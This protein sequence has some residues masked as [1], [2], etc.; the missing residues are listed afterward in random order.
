MEVSFQLR[1]GT[2]GTLVG[3]ICW[4]ARVSTTVTGEAR[5]GRLKARTIKA[6]RIFMAVGKLF[7]G[8]NASARF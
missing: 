2:S 1:T 6:E 3:L 4:L 5:S 8:G 7:A